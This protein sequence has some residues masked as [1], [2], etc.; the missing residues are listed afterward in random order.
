MRATFPTSV[1]AL[2]LRLCVLEGLWHLPTANALRNIT[3]DD[4][5]P[6]IVYSPSSSWTRIDGPN[7]DAAGGHMLAED[8]PGATATITFT[9]VSVYFMS[10]LWPYRVRDNLVIDGDSP[11]T[12]D[13][14]DYS[15][16]DVGYGSGTVASSV[17][18]WYEGTESS[19]HT[20]V[21]SVPPGDKYT[22]VD[23]FI[24]TVLDSSDPTPTTA[25]V[26]PATNTVN[27]PPSGATGT[28]TIHFATGTHTGSPAATGNPGSDRSSAE[29]NKAHNLAIA[30]AVIGTLLGL[31]LLAAI[32]WLVRR[33]RRRRAETVGSITPPIP[34]IVPPSVFGGDSQGGRDINENINNDGYDAYRPLDTMDGR[35]STSYPMAEAGLGLVQNSDASSQRN[36]YRQS[37]Y[38][39]SSTMYQSPAQQVQQPTSSSSLWGASSSRSSRLQRGDGLSS[40][41]QIIVNKP[42]PTYL[43]NTGTG[44]YSPPT[45]EV[46]SSNSPFDSAFGYGEGSEASTPRPSISKKKSPSESSTQ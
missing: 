31:L 40:A 10:T 46:P 8:D 6:R 14:Q 33:H 2:V 5:D 11:I 20:I 23:M 9:F 29:S 35:P 12:L 4:Q 15:V 38:D 24:F 28:G 34:P 32:L 1:F 39:G 37:M 22:I 18:A 3:V 41:A 19:E 16:P 27:F 36:A 7:L 21:V 25:V 13:L 30:M 44:Y 43:A 26:D 45:E 17:V 42:P